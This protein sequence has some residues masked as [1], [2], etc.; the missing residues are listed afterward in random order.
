[1]VRPILKI[2]AHCLAEQQA[3]EAGAVD[4][5]L[6]LHQTAILQLHRADVAAAGIAMHG[7]D[8]SLHA[9]YP[10]GLGAAAQEGCVQCRVKMIGIA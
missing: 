8:A 3:A 10:I 5:Q 7:R 6:A 4:E 1:P 9:A 2:D